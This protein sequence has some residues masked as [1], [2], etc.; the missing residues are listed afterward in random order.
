MLQFCFLNIG[1]L[2]LE[3]KRVFPRTLNDLFVNRVDTRQMM[4]IPI[5]W[6][7]TIFCYILYTNLFYF[8]ENWWWPIR[9]LNHLEI[10]EHLIKPLFMHLLKSN[11]L[12]N[13]ILPPHRYFRIMLPIKAKEYNVNHVWTYLKI[14]YR[15]EVCAQEIRF[16]GPQLI[17][18]VLEYFMNVFVRSPYLHLIFCT[19]GLHK[20]L[21]W[22][23]FV[24]RPFLRFQIHQ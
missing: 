20:L 17:L 3:I 18:E 24:G 23:H 8:G 10:R 13:H 16:L 12:Y 6:W 2:R 7:E 9:Y 4:S 15:R 1:I 22:V 11:L 14:C 21:Y 5:R 19:E